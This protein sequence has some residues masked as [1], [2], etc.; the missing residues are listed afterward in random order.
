MFLV[1]YSVFGEES[2]SRYLLYTARPEKGTKADFTGFKS[3]YRGIS[4]YPVT[5]E[6]SI[7]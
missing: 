6:V 5:Y 2:E 1:D 4:R 3:R 7:Y